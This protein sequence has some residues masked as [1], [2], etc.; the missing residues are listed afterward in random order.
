[1]AENYI[2]PVRPPRGRPLGGIY[3]E[4]LA[5][6]PSERY[7]DI[8]AICTKFENENSKTNRQNIFL[9]PL[10]KPHPL[11]YNILVPRGNRKEE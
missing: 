9:K 6:Y 7:L 1:L 2:I 3:F 8:C 5:Y 4:S 11:C 10:D